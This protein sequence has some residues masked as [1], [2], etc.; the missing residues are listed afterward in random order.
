MKFPGEKLSRLCSSANKEVILVAPF[1]KA[2]AI[3]RLLASIPDCVSKIKCATRWHPREIAAGVSDLEVFDILSSSP[4]AELFLNPL[5]HAKYYRIDDV[6]LIGS[7]NLTQRGL[8]WIVPANLELL[9]QTPSDDELTAFEQQLFVTSRLATADIRNEMATA[10]AQILSIPNTIQSLS[11]ENPYFADSPTPPSD[12]WLPACHNPEY[13]FRIYSLRDID[14]ILSATLHAGERD[15]QTLF[16]P[17]GLDESGFNKFVSA[18]IQQTPMFQRIYESSSKKRLTPLDGQ[19]LIS[20]EVEPRHFFH[21]TEVHWE[22]I[23]SYLLY[24]YP[25]V[26]RRPSGSD[27]LQRGTVVG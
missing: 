26:Y 23:L 1:I 11:D 2:D 25:H 20:T 12:S 27:D 14:S 4:R 9:V 21:T 5:L 16:I 15:I 22:I 3:K 6:Y 10:V 24:F 19:Q 7:A 18:S 13:L 17:P 8:G